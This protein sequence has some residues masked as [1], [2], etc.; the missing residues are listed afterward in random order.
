LIKYKHLDY[1]ETAPRLH[2][3]CV[4]FSRRCSL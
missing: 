1:C 2:G 4:L 3:V